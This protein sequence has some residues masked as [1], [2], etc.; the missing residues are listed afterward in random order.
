MPVMTR[1][2]QIKSALELLDPP[3]GRRD[4][5]E[6]SISS[7]LDYIDREATAGVIGSKK[8][9]IALGRFEKSLKGAENARR[10]L[11]GPERQWIER[12]ARDCRRSISRPGLP[13]ANR[14]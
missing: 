11:I 8:Y 7:A 14:C 2:E 13:I 1:D 3:P 5:C 9:K 6:R 12:G 10:K 4:E